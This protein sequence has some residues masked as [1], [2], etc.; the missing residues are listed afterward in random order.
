MGIGFQ[1]KDD[2]LDYTSNIDILGKNTFDDL[3][4][5]IVTAP[6]LFA[7]ESNKD[8]SSLLTL[9]ELQ[10]IKKENVK[11]IFDTILHNENLKSKRNYI[12]KTQDLV[13]AYINNSLL[14][15]NKIIPLE[16]TKNNIFL[17]HLLNI[18]KFVG[19]RDK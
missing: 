5:G 13:N 18:I 14:I 17:E 10:K 6:Y 16:N 15:L 12:T 11:K 2:M 8:L 19:S 1:I 9:I 7:Y 4:K 3:Y